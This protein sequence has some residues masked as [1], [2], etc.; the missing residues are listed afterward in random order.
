[1]PF[2]LELTLW[3]KSVFDILNTSY[4]SSVTEVCD[5]HTRPCHPGSHSG[6]VI[7][8]MAAPFGFAYPEKN[9]PAPGCRSSASSSGARAP[10][11][12]AY[13]DGTQTTSASVMDDG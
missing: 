11:P 1:M 7:F 6:L 8:Q 12:P 9:L 3:L 2:A 5:G 13:S 10:R 4:P